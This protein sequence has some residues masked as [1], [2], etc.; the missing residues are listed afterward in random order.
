[1]ASD[2]K[3]LIDSSL[4]ASKLAMEAMMVTSAC[5]GWEAAGASALALGLVIGGTKV[6][7]GCVGWAVAGVGSRVLSLSL[8]SFASAIDFES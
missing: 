2:W 7:G 1:M 5:V 8:M 6:T 4:G 3:S